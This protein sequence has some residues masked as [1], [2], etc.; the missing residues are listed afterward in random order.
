MAKKYLIHNSGSFEEQIPDVYS[1]G[2][3]SAGNLI[4]LN[5]SGSIDV[6]FLNLNLTVDLDNSIKTNY[7]NANFIYNNGN[8]TLIEYKDTLNQNVFTKE[9]TYSSGVLVSS[10]LTRISDNTTLNTNYTFISGSLTQKTY[11]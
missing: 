8:V 4:A 6:S 11:S 1:S 7:V 5:E 2:I 10:L 9:F 3:G